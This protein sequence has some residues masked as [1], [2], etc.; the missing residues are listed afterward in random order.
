[1]Y[2][3]EFDL[4]DP[5]LD[6]LDAM[7]F[8]EAS[9]IQEQ[10]IPL[11]LEGRDIIAVAQTGTGKTAAYL[12]PIISRLSRLEHPEDRVN[13]VIMA[14]TRELALQI[15]HQ[16]EAFG[17]FLPISALSIYGGTDGIVWEQQ[18][19][20]LS[21]GTDI[22][23][24]TPGRLLSLLRLG[25]ADLSA[26]DYFVLDEADRML[27][28]GFMDDIME[29]Y[30]ELPES[31]QTLLF[32]ATM[33]PKIKK[34]AASILK[35]PKEVEIA[36]SKPPESILQSA[37][38]CYEA[39]KLPLLKKLFQETPP[40]RTIIFSSSKLKVKSLAQSLA[41]LGIA[42]REMHSDLGQADR[43]VV[44]RDFKN[45][46]ID[47]LVAT[48]IVARGIDID[49]IRIVINFD[50]PRDPEDYVHRIGRTAR[51]NND[52]GLAITFVSPE[53]QGDFASIERLLERTIYKLPIEEEFGKTPEYT[54]KSIKKERPKRGSVP[55]RGGGRASAKGNPQRRRN[56]KTINK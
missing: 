34:L 53:E 44:M 25:E 18:K 14:P 7:N 50:V 40:K 55:K 54:G 10:A 39:Q 31:C 52:S 41:R 4:D 29:I 45:G 51:G 20:S 9:P 33:P 5:I 28:M 17:Y 24:A 1:M 46:H 38:I 43:E 48:D 37:Y 49:D 27:D 8:I 21:S 16:V 42:V 47:L 32:S 56:N 15:D 2:F 6:A 11:I 19:R 3:D 26:V 22:V 23:I 36:I 13:V 30:K 35:D 12:L